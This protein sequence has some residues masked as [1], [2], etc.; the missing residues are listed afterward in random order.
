MPPPQSWLCDLDGVL[1]K[2]GSMVPGADRF[3]EALEHSGRSFLILTNN[4]MLTPRDL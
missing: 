2:E 3:V 4:S 1:V